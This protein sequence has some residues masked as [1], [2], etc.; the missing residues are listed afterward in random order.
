MR[1]ERQVERREHRHRLAKI[2]LAD[3]LELRH[4]RRTEKALVAQHARLRERRQLIAVAG[5]HAA[6]ESD[7]NMTPAASGAPL[8]VEPSRCR[9]RRD[10]VER[11]V[12]EGRDATGCCGTRRVLKAFPIGAPR[13]VDVDMRVH[14][15]GEHD[16]TPGIDLAGAGRMLDGGQTMNRRD[17]SV[18]DLDR[19]RTDA[20][21]Q[22]DA[23]AFDDESGAVHHAPI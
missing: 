3:V 8:L 4:A 9:R 20:V 13:I 12:H 1:Q 10:A 11:H 18:V 7:I 14:E 23:L 2:A 5:D 22:N 17:P 21:G 16:E 6:P 19:G 15:S